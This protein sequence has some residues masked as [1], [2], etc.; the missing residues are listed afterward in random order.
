MEE[1]EGYRANRVN[2]ALG[3]ADRFAAILK[4]YLNAPDI[5]RQRLYLEMIDEVLPAL[6]HVYVVEE[7]QTQPIPL[8][9]L[10][11]DAPMNRHGRKGDA[12]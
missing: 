7:G 6:Q 12:Q 1:A 10:G 8:L 3:E 9:H 2:S 5:T 11:E 4:E